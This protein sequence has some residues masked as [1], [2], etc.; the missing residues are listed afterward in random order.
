MQNHFSHDVLR[1]FPANNEIR[2]STE[3]IDHELRGTINLEVLIDMGEENGFY[4]PDVLNR[5]EQAATHV[6]S[7]EMD[8]LFIG[9][10]WSLTTILKEINQ[11]LN[12]NRPEFYTIPQERDLVAQEFLLFENSGSDDL[13]D[14]VDSQ[15][16]KVR[17]TIKG[18]FEDAVRYNGLIESVQH[19]FEENISRMPPSPSPA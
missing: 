1:W 7:L 11:A 13:E 6:E 4:D 14:V 15:F 2:Q 5:L 19:Y 8:G 18:P 10:A 9:K 16:S 17:F 12:E 3:K